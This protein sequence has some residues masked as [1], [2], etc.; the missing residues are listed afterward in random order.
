M[1]IFW[2]FIGLD[3]SKTKLISCKAKNV[4][5]EKCIST[6]YNFVTRGVFVLARS[7]VNYFFEKTGKMRITA[8]L[9]K[10]CPL[11]ILMNVLLTS[12]IGLSGIFTTFGILILVIGILNCC[13]IERR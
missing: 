5:G 1:V 12:V 9:K 6:V 10:I 2:K 8:T 11:A 3:C 13:F 7:E 4:N